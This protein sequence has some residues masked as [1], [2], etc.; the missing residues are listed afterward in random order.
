MMMGSLEQYLNLATEA[1]TLLD[2]GSCAIMNGRREEVF[3]LLREKGLPRRNNE[4]Y[5]Y[6]HV[7]DAFAPDYGINLQRRLPAEDPYRAYRCGVPHI[8]SVLGFMVNDCPVLSDPQ[9]QSLPE[10]VTLCSIREAA[11]RFPEMLEAYYHRAASRQYDGVTALNTLLAQDGIFVHIPEGTVLSQPLQIVNVIA[12][13]GPVMSNRRLLVVAGRHSSASLLVCDH[14]S[15]DT[16]SLATQVNE[17]YVDEGARIELYRVEETHT[18]HTLF[19]Q[20]YVEQQADSRFHHHSVTLTCGRS[21]ST[22]DIRLSGEGAQ[23]AAEGAVVTDGKQQADYNLL[24]EHAAARC[25]SDLLYKYVLGGESVGA[26][27][28][29]VLVQPGAQQSLSEQNN[30]NL[31]TS[32]GAH[33]YSQPMLEIYNDDVKCNHGSGTGKLDE[34]ALFY[35]RQRGIPE[36]EARLLLQ[37]AFINDVLARVTIE[38][39]RERLSHLVEMRFRGGLSKCSDCNLCK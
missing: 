8:G 9:L 17:I 25:Q 22:T 31:C 24:V 35:M 18:R 3:R 12:S 10:G 26:Y 13:T 14:T 16:P 27:A 30:A 6:C 39:L 5:K 29:K 1:R 37:H 33:A 2:R 34:T 36:A 4:R 15:G 23:V 19:T 7:E 32:L 11:M 21:R 20:T 38:G 28:G